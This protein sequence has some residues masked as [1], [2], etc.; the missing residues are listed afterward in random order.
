MSSLRIQYNGNLNKNKGL[1]DKSKDPKK[2]PK[3]STE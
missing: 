3:F 1:T 2:K